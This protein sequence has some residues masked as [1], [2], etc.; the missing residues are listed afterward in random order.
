[1][2][3]RAIVLLSLPAILATATV[4]AAPRGK[5]ADATNHT[6]DGFFLRLAL[7]MGHENLNVNTGDGELIDLS[8]F[9]FGL[10]IA[11]GG[12]IVPN[13]ALHADIFGSGVIDPNVSQN[14][15]E[16]GELRDSTMTQ[17]AIGIGATYHFMPINL[18]VGL[19]LGVGVVGLESPES[20]LD[21]DP[22]FAMN[23]MVG[24]EFWVGDDWGIGVAAQLIYN[25]VPTNSDDSSSDWTSF[26]I[27]FS[28]TYN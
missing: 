11:I 26:N 28:A 1:M 17:S 20:N 23:A 9:G 15:V 19:S 3:R 13:L 18:Y 5:N 27:L 10:S 4:H 21:A 14:G 7:G 25:H 16:L 2:L 12:T 24:K 22:G 6:H 8:G